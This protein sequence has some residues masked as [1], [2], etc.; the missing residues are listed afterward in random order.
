MLIESIYSIVQCSGFDTSG[1]MDLTE[2]EAKGRRM[3]A[4]EMA[5][6]WEGRMKGTEGRMKGAGRR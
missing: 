5:V 6:Q 4:E 2:R 1:R 3:R